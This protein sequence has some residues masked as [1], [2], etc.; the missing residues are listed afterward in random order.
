LQRLQKWL[1][2][3]ILLKADRKGN[4]FTEVIPQIGARK[5]SADPF[6]WYPEKDINAEFAATYPKGSEF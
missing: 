3:Q 5:T 6:V 2:A 1:G 4:A